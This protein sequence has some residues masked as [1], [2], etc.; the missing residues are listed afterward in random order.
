V[1]L[2][3][4]NGATPVLAI[5]DAL[6][7]SLG[8]D[9]VA[10]EFAAHAVGSSTCSCVEMHLSGESPSK[11]GVGSIW[12]VGI[13]SDVATSKLRAVVSA[14]NTLV[15]S[16]QL[17]PAK[18]RYQRPPTLRSETWFKEFKLRA[19]HAPVTPT[20]TEPRAIEASS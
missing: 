16:K 5:I 9:P 7:S 4:G 6:H 11:S 15:G 13:S 20:E 3:Q 2:V 14:V 10:G 8:I 19:G 17:P 1:R 12:G 18:K